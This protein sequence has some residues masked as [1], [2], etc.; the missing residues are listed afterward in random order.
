MLKSPY[1]RLEFDDVELCGSEPWR[2]GCLS[3]TAWDAL[4]EPPQGIIGLSA[5]ALRL[6]PEEAPSESDSSCPDLGTLAKFP[7]NDLATSG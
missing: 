7:L 5:P 1:S 3:Q 2:Q 4:A 6:L